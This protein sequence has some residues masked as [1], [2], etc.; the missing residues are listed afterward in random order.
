MKLEIIQ[1]EKNVLEFYIEGER[2]TLPIMLKEKIAAQP[3][4]EFCAY[5]MDHPMDK[6]SRFIVKTEGKSPKKIIEDAIKQAKEELAEFK[7]DFD[8]LK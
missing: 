7:K 8:K 3:G 4:V 5:K 6:K 2:H 1:N